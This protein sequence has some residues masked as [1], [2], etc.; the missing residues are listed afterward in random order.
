MTRLIARLKLAF[1]L[2][3]IRHRDAIYKRAAE[4]E[5]LNTFY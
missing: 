3:G 4:F 1:G 2:K 5:T